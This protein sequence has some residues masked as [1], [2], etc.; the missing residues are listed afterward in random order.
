M[1]WK[2][3]ITGNNL[4]K[5]GLTDSRPHGIIVIENKKGGNAYAKNGIIQ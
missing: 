1:R 5:R 4:I 2:I 3:G